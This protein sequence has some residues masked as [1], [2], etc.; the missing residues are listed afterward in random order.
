MK[1]T[2]QEWLKFAEADIMS[3]R[4]LLDE[5]SL[6]NIVAFHSQQ[7]VEKSF[8]ALIEENNLI[9]P[10]IH[11]VQRLYDITKQFINHKI[12]IV[13]LALLDSVYT[14]SRYPGDM[15]LIES[16]MPTKG[17]ATQLYEIAKKI[18]III[19]KTIEK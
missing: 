14:A 8:K 12:D 17:E 18:N 6:S 9:I 15:G 11:S 13:E 4:K 5:E 7:A 10:R 2:T 19:I 3:C 1:T 16:G